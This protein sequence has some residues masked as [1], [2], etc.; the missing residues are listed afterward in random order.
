MLSIVYMH[1]KF[2]STC[3]FTSQV[4]KVV[5]DNW[6]PDKYLST[7]KKCAFSGKARETYAM[8]TNHLWA[9]YSVYFTKNHTILRRPA[10]GRK[11]RTIF[12]QFLRHRT[13]PGE[14]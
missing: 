11:N 2:T 12:Y 13:V 8:V 10:G 4:S 6:T 9:P 3:L 14:V 7:Q 5:C 1:C